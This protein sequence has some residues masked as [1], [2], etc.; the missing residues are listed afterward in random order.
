MAYFIK[1]IQKINMVGPRDS[2]VRPKRYGGPCIPKCGN[3]QRPILC[4]QLE[5]TLQYLLYYRLYIQI[6]LLILPNSQVVIQWILMSY[7]STIFVTLGVG[8]INTYTDLAKFTGCYPIFVL[9]CVI[10]NICYIKGWIYKFIHWFGK[11]QSLLY[12]ICVL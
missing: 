10:Y 5:L 9:H 11:I 6:H 7:C 12:N 3:H 4:R 8:S 2:N 1:N